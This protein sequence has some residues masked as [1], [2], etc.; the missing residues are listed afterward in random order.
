MDK[1]A[2]KPDFVEINFDSP[3]WGL[4]G[5]PPIE[6][7]ELDYAPLTELVEQGDRALS[8]FASQQRAIPLTVDSDGDRPVDGTERRA[9]IRSLTVRTQVERGQ[10]DGKRGG[11]GVREDQQESKGHKHTQRSKT[12]NLRRGKPFM[13]IR[14]SR[15]MKGREYW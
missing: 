10:R 3:E 2:C 7:P 11:Y 4:D 6:S 12:R 9:D 5:V 8:E 1:S 15:R 14:W 13:S